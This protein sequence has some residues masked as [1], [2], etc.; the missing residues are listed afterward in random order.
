MNCPRCKVKLHNDSKYCPRCGLLFKSNDIEKYTEIFN[1]DYIDIYFKEY[2]N[3]NLGSLS[4]W[5]FLFGCFYALYKKMYKIAVVG[6]F[7]L[8]MFM[9]VSIR[10]L[11]FITGSSGFLFLPVVFMLAGPIAVH[12]YFSFHFDR[13]LIDDRKTRLNKLLKENEDKSEDEIIQAIEKD[14]KN[15]IALAIIAAIITIPISIYIM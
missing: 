10:S 14:S 7:C 9:F 13:L 11:Y 3:I 12:L 2:K 1:T 5:Y 6:Y 15:N 8:L 4:L